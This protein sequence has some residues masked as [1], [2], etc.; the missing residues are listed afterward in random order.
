MH[1]LICNQIHSKKI[2]SVV[3]GKKIMKTSESI[4]CRRKAHNSQ[5]MGTREKKKTE[6]VCRKQN[7]FDYILGNALSKPGCSS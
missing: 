1:F 4:R 5:K 2:Y 7:E 6:E 3:L